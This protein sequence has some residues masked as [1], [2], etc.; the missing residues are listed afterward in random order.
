M[1]SSPSSKLDE[2]LRSDSVHDLSS[3]SF[4]SLE[5]LRRGSNSLF[6]AAKSQVALLAKESKSASVGGSSA[7]VG[8]SSPFGLVGRAR[9]PPLRLKYKKHTSKIY[10]LNPSQYC[11]MFE[12]K[13][14]ILNEPS[15]NW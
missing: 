4:D 2:H 5:R 7:A 10:T 1:E 11:F 14:T 15:T 8:P 9:S 3:V 13:N 6:E 12:S